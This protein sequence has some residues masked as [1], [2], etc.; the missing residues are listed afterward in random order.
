M[1]KTFG[2]K[3][4]QNPGEYGQVFRMGLTPPMQTATSIQL[5]LI[6]HD[7]SQVLKQK[8]DEKN[9]QEK[10]EAAAAAVEEE[11]NIGAIVGGTVGGVAG[12][13]MFLVLVM[14][15]VRRKNKGVEQGPVEL[16]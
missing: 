8:A 15:L 12:A 9:K 13:I 7:V 2:K 3:L 10:K 14:F 1:L 16:A 5:Q 6:T 11:D 4:F